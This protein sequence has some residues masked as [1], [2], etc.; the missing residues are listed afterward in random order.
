[1]IRVILNNG[2]HDYVKAAILNTLISKGIV[3]ALA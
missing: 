1:M 3:I 2:K